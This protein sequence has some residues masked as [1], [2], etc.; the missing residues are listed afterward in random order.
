[1]IKGYNN[2]HAGSKFQASGDQSNSGGVKPRFESM[3]HACTCLMPVLNY[4]KV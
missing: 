2:L 3:H 1:M 4:W